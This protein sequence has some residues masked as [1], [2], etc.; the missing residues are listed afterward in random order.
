MV[1]WSPP[2]L[3][4]TVRP[5]PS[6]EKSAKIFHGQGQR[7]NACQGLGMPSIRQWLSQFIK[8]VVISIKLKN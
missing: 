1:T 7:G 4:R 5:Y 2:V 6:L 8:Q 3:R